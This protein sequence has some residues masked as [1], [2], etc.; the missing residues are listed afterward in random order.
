MD[1]AID[2]PYHQPLLDGHLLDYLLLVLPEVKSLLTD[3]LLDQ[4][5][6]QVRVELL[7]VMDRNLI[8]NGIEYALCTGVS[9]LSADSIVADS[10]GDRFLQ[11]PRDGLQLISQ[12]GDV[13]FE[14]VLRILTIQALAAVL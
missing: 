8:D 1:L 12:V 3:L 4:L 5:P 13:L 11:L 14:Q 10:L 7:L 2:S 9:L 6:L